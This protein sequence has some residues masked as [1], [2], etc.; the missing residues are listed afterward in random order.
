[1]SSGCPCFAFGVAAVQQLLPEQALVSGEAA[2]EFVVVCL[3]ADWCSVCRD[4]AAAFNSLA[5]RFPAVGFYWLDIE[6]HADDLGD[7]E[8]ENFPTLLIKRR[9]HILFFGAMPPAP[10]HLK[11]TLEAFLQQSEEESRHYAGSG[12]ERRAWQEDGDLQR[13]GSDPRGR[14]RSQVAGEPAAPCVEPPGLPLRRPLP[15]Q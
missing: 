3:C 13:L 7:L 14:I 2:G 15:K 4:Y 10:V 1:M 8:V 6:V 11:R 5:A 12:V 9:Q